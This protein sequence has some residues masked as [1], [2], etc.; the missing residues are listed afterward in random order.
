V[1]QR[2][3]QIGSK[4]GPRFNLANAIIIE[5]RDERT[6]L[7]VETILHKTANVLGAQ[8]PKFAG[9]GGTEWFSMQAFNKVREIVGTLSRSLDL[10]VLEGDTAQ[11]FWTKIQAEIPPKQPLHSWKERAAQRRSKREWDF[12]ASPEGRHNHE[13]RQKLKSILLEPSTT[14]ISRDP[15]SFSFTSP[16]LEMREKSDREMSR[17]ERGRRLR[18]KSYF[19]NLCFIH[20][21]DGVTSWGNIIHHYDSPIQ[22][23]CTMEFSADLYRVSDLS[24][25]DL[26][27]ANKGDGPD[28]TAWLT[29]ELDEYKRF[30][31]EVIHLLE[32]RR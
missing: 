26:L 2:I 31:A 18:P 10:H 15:A 27:S 20:Y 1:L 11:R 6:S 30:F 4:D 23:D 9:D 14:F 7:D 16:I 24:M 12:L 8:L 22:K 29:N 17:N 5:A 3:R 28:Y 32:V 21:L 13:A 25:R 19:F